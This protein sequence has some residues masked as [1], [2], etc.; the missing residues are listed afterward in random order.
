MGGLVAAA[1][2]FGAAPDFVATEGERAWANGALARLHWP[3]WRAR[4]ALPGDTLRV[5]AF[6]LAHEDGHL[7]RRSAMMASQ[8]LAAEAARAWTYKRRQR[9][10]A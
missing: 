8:S 10:W 2:A 4:L 9:L 5:E 6:R 7:T 1:Q 3:S